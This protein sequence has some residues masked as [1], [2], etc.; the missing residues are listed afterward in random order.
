MGPIE[1]QRADAASDFL[2]SAG[3]RP[4]GSAQGRDDRLEA[5]MAINE[6]A[7]P[8]ELK[9]SKLPA[10]FWVLVGMLLGVTAFGL[11]APTLG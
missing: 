2:L 5:R 10:L 6:L 8:R 1:M 9:H 7:Q 11:A 3:Y 4:K